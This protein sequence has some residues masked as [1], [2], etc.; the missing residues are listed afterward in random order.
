M[1]LLFTVFL[2]QKQIFLFEKYF[3]SVS[4]YALLFIFH[5]IY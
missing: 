4:I 1:I 3:I 5:I 2:F